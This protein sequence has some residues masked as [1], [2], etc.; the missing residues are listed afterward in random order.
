MLSEGLSELEQGLREAGPSGRQLRY[1]LLRHFSELVQQLTSSLASD[2]VPEAKA[3]E[4]ASDK[5][6]VEA[7]ETHEV[8]SHGYVDA[9]YLRTVRREALEIF[10]VRPLGGEDYVALWIDAVPVRGR[11][12]LLCMG[13]TADGYRQV[14]DFQD[15]SLQEAAAL[16]SGLLD[17]GLCVDRGLLCITPGNAQL[18]RTLAKQFGPHSAMF[19]R[20]K[21][22][23]CQM[24][25]RERVVSAM[26]G[27]CG[28]RSRGPFSCPTWTRP[29]RRS[30]GFMPNCSHATGRRPSGCCRTWNR[31]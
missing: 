12:L 21:E 27:A 26:G 4:P 5:G 22:Q 16:F 2:E 25:K 9:A 18:S 30:C 11:P 15:A 10:E 13:V 28:A 7:L 6:P 24:H 17:R 20:L 8:P 31:R 3:A 29:A 1:A 19:H 23:H 14:L